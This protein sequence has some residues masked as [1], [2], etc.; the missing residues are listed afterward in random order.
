MIKKFFLLTSRHIPGRTVVLHGN[1]N[2]SAVKLP[3]D[4]KGKILSR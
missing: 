2:F 4:N 3:L 1:D